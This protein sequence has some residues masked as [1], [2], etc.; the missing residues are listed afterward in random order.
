MPEGN[1]GPG[2]GSGAPLGSVSVGFEGKGDSQ[3][4]NDQAIDR[5]TQAAIA[6]LDA[7][8]IPVGTI[9]YWYGTVN[10]VPGGWYVCDGTNSTPNLTTSYLGTHPLMM[11]RGV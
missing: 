6:R 1:F 5:A 7:E 4:R 10:D 3:L 8:K 2:G 11:W 9:V